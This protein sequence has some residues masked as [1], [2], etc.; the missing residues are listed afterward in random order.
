MTPKVVSD[1]SLKKEL[2]PV[3]NHAEKLEENGL[4]IYNTKI[5]ASVESHIFTFLSFQIFLKFWVNL[6]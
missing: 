2:F 6:I 3:E 5:L 4:E 1:G